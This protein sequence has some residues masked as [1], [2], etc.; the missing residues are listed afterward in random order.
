MKI[1][2]V[3]SDQMREIETLMVK[4][5]ITLEQTMENAGRNLAS[6]A[7]SKF[8]NG[9]AR[10]KQVLVLAGTGENGGSVMV[11]ARFLHN[12]GADVI[13]LMTKSINDMEGATKHQ[14]LILENMGLPLHLTTPLTEL[15]FPFKVDIILDGI[16]GYN[17]RGEPQGNAAILIKTANKACLPILSLDVPSGMDATTGE[18]YGELTIKATATM[19]LGLPKIGLYSENGS[20]YVGDLFLADIGI[21]VELYKELDMEIPDR[22]IFHKGNVLKLRIP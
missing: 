2:K 3:S 10:G 22:G 16:I 18:I 12:W 9:D 11:A 8:L 17:L 20:K 13:V 21:P 6:L 15:E 19:A 14:A 5:Q 4:Y 1:P 7:R